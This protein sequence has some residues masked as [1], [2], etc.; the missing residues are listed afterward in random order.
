MGEGGGG[1]EEKERKQ[2][3]RLRGDNL[4]YRPSKDHRTHKSNKGKGRRWRGR[5]QRREY[6]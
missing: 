5:G 6:D 3:N 2:K 4:K 1:E